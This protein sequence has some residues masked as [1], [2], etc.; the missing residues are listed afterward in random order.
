MVRR[1]NP[2]A[3]SIPFTFLGNRKSLIYLWYKVKKV[4]L[5]SDLKA[6]SLWKYCLKINITSFPSS[7]TG[8]ALSR[9]YLSP[10]FL[11]ESWASMRILLA[12]FYVRLDP[13]CPTT[14]DVRQNFRLFKSMMKN[15]NDYIMTI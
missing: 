12:F 2:Y 10:I 3:E 11:A 7:P 1:K 14:I 9:T 6:N 4:K 13:K 8:S 5:L 15:V